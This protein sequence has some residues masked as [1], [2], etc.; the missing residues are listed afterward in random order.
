MLRQLFLTPE[1][2]LHPRY[3]T[4]YFTRAGWLTDWIRAAEDLAQAAWQ[5]YK[6]S[7]P[8]A[9]ASTT[10]TVSSTV[11]SCYVLSYCYA[12]RNQVPRRVSLT[13]WPTNPLS[14]TH[15]RNG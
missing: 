11:V 1:L 5:A 9:A 8:V 6:P 4:T 15:W 13:H 2:V 7:S 3:K 10:T 14:S 12:R